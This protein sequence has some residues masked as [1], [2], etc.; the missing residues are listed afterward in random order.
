MSSHAP[1]LHGE[2]DTRMFACAAEATKRPYK[3]I[4]NCAVDTDV[5]GVKKVRSAIKV[6]P[7]LYLAIM[8]LMAFMSVVFFTVDTPDKK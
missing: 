3:K 6:Y 2:A 7:R 8:C 5:K 1:C 4:S